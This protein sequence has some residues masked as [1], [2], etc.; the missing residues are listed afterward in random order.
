MAATNLPLDAPLPDPARQ[1]WRTYAERLNSGRRRE[2]HAEL[3]RFLVLIGETDRTDGERFCRWLCD[4][5]LERG[6]DGLEFTLAERVVRPY[7]HGAVLEGRMPHIRWL[8]A[9]GVAQR[10]A[11][12]VAHVVGVDTVLR[13][14]IAVDPFDVRSW[15]SL[16]SFHVEIADWRAHHLDESK[17]V[18]PEEECLEGLRDARRILGLAP[19][20]AIEAG[21]VA[22]LEDLEAMFA[23][24]RDYDESDR[25]LT[26]PQFTASRGHRYWFSRAY[27]YSDRPH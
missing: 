21:D 14:A 24:W 10:Q 9:R 13:A 19:A 15:R 17:L 22:W 23:D 26:F 8:L 4:W 12:D 2:A 20:G 18:A 11:D 1:A 7:L 25:S 27:Y 5:C 16:F 6:R 3:D